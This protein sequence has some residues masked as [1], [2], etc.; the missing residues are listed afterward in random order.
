MT[1][2]EGCLQLRDQ[3]E[4]QQAGVEE[5]LEDLKNAEAALRVERRLRKRAEKELADRQH[6]RAEAEDARIVFDYW[7]Q[8]IKG[9]RAKSFE[10][11]REKN[12]LDRLQGGYGIEDL[13]RAIDGAAIDAFAKDG[14]VYNDLELICRDATYV[15]RFIEAADRHLER[16]QDWIEL[17]SFGEVLAA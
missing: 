2:C 17:E 12:V 9:G 14:R 3:L 4:R 7:N 11:K 10:G 1:T 6:R 8:T 13:C 15:D 16:V 5:L